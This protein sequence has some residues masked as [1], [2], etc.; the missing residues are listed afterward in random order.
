VA[1]ATSTVSD[2]RMKQAE[3]EAEEQAKQIYEKE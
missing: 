1:T 2:E 3:A